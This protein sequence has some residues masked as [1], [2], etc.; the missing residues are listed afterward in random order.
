MP[1]PSELLLTQGIPVLVLSSVPHSCREQLR[2][3]GLD[4]DILHANQ[5]EALK[6]RGYTCDLFED[7]V[8][9]VLSC[10][11]PLRL[12]SWTAL[13]VLGSTW[14]CCRKQLSRLD[15]SAVLLPWH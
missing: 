3:D 9:Y 12:Y 8:E 7:F 4:R 15:S 13:S 10:A 11:L 6:R 5:K 2:R 14:I 1:L